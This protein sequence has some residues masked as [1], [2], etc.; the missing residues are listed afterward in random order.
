MCLLPTTGGADDDLDL[1][2]FQS[3]RSRPSTGSVA[4]QRAGGSASKPGHKKSQSLSHIEVLG[5]LS[6]QVQTSPPRGA[7]VSH[8]QPLPTSLQPDISDDAFGETSGF[9]LRKR[10]PQPAEKS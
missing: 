1:L 2:K 4:K 10:Q 6:S 9:E 7:E 5:S 8:I 3:S